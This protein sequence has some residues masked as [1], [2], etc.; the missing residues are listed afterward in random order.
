LIVSLKQSF[1]FVTARLC[2]NANPK[3]DQRGVLEDVQPRSYDPELCQRLSRLASAYFK[4]KSRLVTVS[5][6]KLKSF[7]SVSREC[8]IS[9]VT[10]IA[11]IVI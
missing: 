10:N 2:Q 4:L 6:E 3:T 7:S 11:I 5:I 1:D 9:F 8:L